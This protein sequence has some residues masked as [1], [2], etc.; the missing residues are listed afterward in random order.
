MLHYTLCTV[1]MHLQLFLEYD[2]AS[3]IITQQQAPYGH[4]LNT[5]FNRLYSNAMGRSVSPNEQ[6]LA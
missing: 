3:T 6:F 5:I 1:F 4:A 2:S